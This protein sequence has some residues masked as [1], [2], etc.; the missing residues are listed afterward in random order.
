MI[1]WTCVIGSA[2]SSS[3]REKTTSCRWRGSSGMRTPIG[4]TVSPVIDRA[5][6]RLRAAGGALSARE[7]QRL[8]LHVDA[9]RA[10]L[11]DDFVD[12]LADGGPLAGR[13]RDV[14]VGGRVDALDQV[15]VEVK[16]LPPVRELVQLDHRCSWRL[17]C[18]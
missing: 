3:P 6:G 12:R 11:R 5:Q 15:A 13:Q 8:R 17:G 10:D 16:R 1:S 9:P 7:A 18:S 2:Y 14:A 4:R